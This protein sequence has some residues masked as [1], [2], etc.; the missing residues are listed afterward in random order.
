MPFNC[1]ENICLGALKTQ[2]SVLFISHLYK[3][4]GKLYMRYQFGKKDSNASYLRKPLD[5]E[6]LYRIYTR[7]CFTPTKI[8]GEIN[9]WTLIL[10]IQS[11]KQTFQYTKHCCLKTKISETKAHRSKNIYIRIMFYVLHIWN[12]QGN[13]MN[14]P[15]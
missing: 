2:Q 11:I 6:D 7:R 14:C 4:Y 8:V 15:P 3:T 9:I 1:P 13:I 12:K 10:S 5:K